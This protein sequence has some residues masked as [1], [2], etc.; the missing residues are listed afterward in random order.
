MPAIKY[1]NTNNVNNNLVAPPPPKKI[2]DRVTLHK[3]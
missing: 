3:R 1:L 2:N